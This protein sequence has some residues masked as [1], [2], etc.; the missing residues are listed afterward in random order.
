MSA[1]PLIR[2]FAA[3][4]VLALLSPLAVGEALSQSGRDR[5]YAELVRQSEALAAIEPTDADRRQ[6]MRATAVT[7]AERLKRFV[8]AETEARDDDKV[9]PP[10]AASLRPGEG[11]DEGARAPGDDREALSDIPNPWF[12][13]YA[14]DARRE[15]SSLIEALDSG[16][17]AAADLMLKAD[18][19]NLL[20]RDL[21]RPPEG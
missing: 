10:P 2:A 1:R 16:Q 4:A 20:L 12:A 9:V 3:L 7:L 15:L 14:T 21:G 8:I 6:L 19:V 17:A 18:T 13:R 5:A 11:G